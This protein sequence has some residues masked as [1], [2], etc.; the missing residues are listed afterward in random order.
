VRLVVGADPENLEVKLRM[1]TVLEDM[2]RRAE[3]LEMVSE[4]EYY[5]LAVASIADSI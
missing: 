2:G 4:G 3:A 1:A 5:H